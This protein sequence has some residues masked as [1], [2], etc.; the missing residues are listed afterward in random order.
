MSDGDIVASFEPRA[1]YRGTPETLHGGI[2]ATALDEMLV[3]AGILTERV[4][5][6][7]ATLDLKF[8]SPLSVSERLDVRSR[9]E[10][11]RGRR[12]VAS[13]EIIAQG[14]TTAEATGLLL[15]TEEIDELFD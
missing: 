2:A 4:M 6:V 13:G 5:S 15:V 12:L 10:E 1:H 14:A 11:R 7:T 8:R 3:W 9:I